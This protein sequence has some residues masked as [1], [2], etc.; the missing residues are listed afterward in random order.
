MRVVKQGTAR[1]VMVFMTQ[2]ADH[3]SGA[4]GLTLTITASKD[5]GAFVS[6]TPT[7]TDRAAGWYNLALTASHTDTLGDFA[8]HVTGSG[9]D[10]AD[11]LMQ[12]VAYDFTDVVRLGL[13][14]LPNVTQGTA[15]S[16]LTSGVGTGQLNVAAGVA[17][18][19]IKTINPAIYGPLVG[20]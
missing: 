3:I 5:G 9:A 2:A 13:T 4:P 15:G 8:L 16:V 19:K 6:I 20:S 7:V 17:D 18:A 10:P 12:V 11:L 1:N 14:A